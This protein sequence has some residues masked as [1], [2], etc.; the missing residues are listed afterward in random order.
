MTCACYRSA[1]SLVTLVLCLPAAAGFAQLPDA[2]LVPEVVVTASRVTLPAARVGSAV[3]VIDRER[4]EASGASVVS[5]LLR[6]VPGLAVNRS[7]PPGSPT[8]VRLRGAEGNHVLV[9]IDGVEANDPAFSSEFDFAHLLTADIER[10]EILRGPQSALWGSDAVGGVI[11]IITRSGR[12]PAQFTLGAEGGSFDTL[13]GSASV[14]GA[15]GAGHYALSA[16]R[17]RTDGVSVAA[18][19]SEDDGYDN[20]TLSFKGGVVLGAG[21]TVDLSARY[22]DATSELDAAEFDDPAS[23]DFGL[24]VDT[25][26]ETDVQQFQ[27]R[28]QGSLTLLDGFWE[29]TVAVALN[30]SD[31]A[32]FSDGRLTNSSEGR[33]LKHEYQSSLRWEIGRTEHTLVLAAERERESFAQRGATADAPRNQNQTTTTDGV[34]GEYRLALDERWFLGTALRHDDNERFDDATTYRLTA[35]R[36]LDGGTR[37]H[38]SLGKGV[39]NPSFTELFGFFPDTFAGNPQLRPETSRGW[40]IGV[41]QT[42]L[43]GRLTFDLT[44]F[45]ADL[46]DEI[47]PVFDPETFISSVAN[48]TGTSERRGLEFAL[49]ARL[50]DDLDLRAHYTY[51]DSEEAG[52]ETEVRRPEH[53]ASLELDWRI[54]DRAGLNLAVTHTG[55]QEDFDFRSFPTDRVTLDDYTVVDLNAR[56]RLS[57]RFTLNA[58][59]ENLLDEDYQDVFGFETPGIGAYVGVQGRF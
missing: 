4:I 1:R 48:A 19:G 33:R 11:N 40:D 22:V 21:A 2:T 34:I 29:Q 16:S 23:P 52:G 9:L 35:A 20:T 12:G 46:D 6:Q 51:T 56:Y 39:K 50:R 45:Q 53:L 3:T 28:L 30:D 8:Q 17:Y 42:L 18:S 32:F 31:N 41:E 36:D 57:E 37:F 14:R 7:G 38:A 49:E 47:I 24:P 5:D 44:W 15:A 26:T 59:V 10:I 13:Q 54:S 27:G 55:E 58:R 43:D 25:D